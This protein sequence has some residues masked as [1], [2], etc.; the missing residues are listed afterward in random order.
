MD[1]NGC[2]GS[3]TTS[4]SGSNIPWSSSRCGGSVA[5][6]L[7]NNR[8]PNKGTTGNTTNH[9]GSILFNHGQFIIIILVLLI[10]MRVYIGR[11]LVGGKPNGGGSWSRGEGGGC[12]GR[13]RMMMLIITVRA[14]HGDVVPSSSSSSRSGGGRITT[15]ARTGITQ[16]DLVFMIVR[17]VMLLMMKMIG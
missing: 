10:M 8:G 14:N 3:G 16:L 6:K 4:T 17:K 11:T 9:T 1:G 15:T 13:C 5:M 7:A 2:V 12:V